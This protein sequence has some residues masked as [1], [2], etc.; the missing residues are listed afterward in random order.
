MKIS[1]KSDNQ[2]L[3]VDPAAGEIHA[4]PDSRTYINF[5]SQYKKVRRRHQGELVLRDGWVCLDYDEE[6]FLCGL[7]VVEGDPVTG[8]SE[9]IP[10]LQP[11]NPLIQ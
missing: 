7:E 6:G 10:Y 8:V 4:S 1:L 3:M 11:I 2:P 9:C 5:N